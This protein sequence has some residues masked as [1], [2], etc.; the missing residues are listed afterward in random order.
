[1]KVIHGADA[2][3]RIY[4]IRDSVSD[5]LAVEEVYNAVEVSE[6]RYCRKIGYIFHKHLQRL[7]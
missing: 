6:A 7:T 3:L 5:N 4:M 1:M 2:E